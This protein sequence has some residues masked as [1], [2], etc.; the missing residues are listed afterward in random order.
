MDL[1]PTARFHPIPV[2]NKQVV[3]NFHQESSCRALSH[4]TRWIQ[5]Y[6]LCR[7]CPMLLLIACSLKSMLFLISYENFL[8]MQVRTLFLNL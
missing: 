2:K 1:Q 3:S 4:L 6:E 7:S 5:C 8:R